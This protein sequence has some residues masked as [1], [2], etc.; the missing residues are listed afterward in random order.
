MRRIEQP[1][2]STNKLAFSNSEVATRL[3][4]YKTLYPLAMLSLPGIASMAGGGIVL[5]K[6]PYVDLHVI[7][8]IVELVSAG[9]DGS[10]NKLSCMQDVQVKCSYHI[11]FRHFV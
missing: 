5:L 11:I 10:D 8:C 3:S 7:N 1:H 6:C 4:N 9:N 2:Q